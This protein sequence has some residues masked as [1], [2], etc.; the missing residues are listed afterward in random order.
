MISELPSN[1][2]L[3]SAGT[4]NTDHHTHLHTVTEVPSNLVSLR[5][6]AHMTETLRP[7]N[8]SAKAS[9]FPASGQFTLLWPFEILMCH[10]QKLRSLKR[11]AHKSTNFFLTQHM[12]HNS[13]YSKQSVTQQH[14]QLLRSAV[15]HHSLETGK[16]RWAH[17]CFS[18]SSSWF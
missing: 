7:C 18:K 11:K 3:P 14:Q 17:T 8:S 6:S 15:Y 1:L 2:N 5:Q 13:Q 12:V 16:E 4:T 9:W 10:L